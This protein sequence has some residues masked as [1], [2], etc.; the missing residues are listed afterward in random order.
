VYPHQTLLDDVW[1]DASTY[2]MV[3][4]D[5][6]HENVKNLKLE[7][8]PDDRTMTLWDAITIRVQWRRTSIDVDPSV[9]ASAS[10]TSSQ[11]NTTPGLIF[12]DTQLD[13]IQLCP[14]QIQEQS[15]RSPP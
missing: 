1:I 14:S 3:K 13:Q 11:P 10:T 4:V 7:V 6:V 5:I 15:C 2:A 12:P 9:A 8:P